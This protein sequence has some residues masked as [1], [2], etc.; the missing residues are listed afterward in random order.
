[1]T[2]PPAL[3]RALRLGFRSILSSG[4]AGALALAQPVA[5]QLVDPDFPSTN[6]T[7]L[8][9]VRV[10]TTLYVGG[11]FTYVGRPTGGAAVVDATSGTPA[12]GLPVVF[13]AVFACASDG[14]GGWYIGGQFTQVGDQPRQNL[15][16]ILADMSVAPWNPGTDGPV[17]A[18]AASGTAVYVGGQFTTLAGVARQDLGAVHASTGAATTWDPQVNDQVFA[19]AVSGDGA[20]V[21]AG[22]YFTEVGGH[23]RLHLAAIRTS[24]GNPTWAPN[25]DQPVTAL[26]LRGTTLYVGGAFGTIDGQSRSAI[27]AINTANGSATAFAPNANSTVYALAVSDDGTIVYAGGGFTSIGGQARS[28]IAA[29]NASDGLATAWD[30]SA[31]FIVHALAAAGSTVYVGG[32]FTSIAGQPVAYGAGLDAASGAMT[33][34]NLVPDSQIRALGVS[35][36]QV[37]AGGYF[38]MVGGTPRRNLAAIDLTTGQVN[39]WDPSANGA[40]LSLGAIGSTIY[41]VG[42]FTSIGGAARSMAGAV[43][44]TTGLATGWQP[45]FQGG[46]DFPSQPWPPAVHDLAVYGSIVYLGGKFAGINGYPRQHLGAV[47]ATNGQPTSWE[48]HPTAGYYSDANVRMLAATSS[49]VGYSQEVLTMAVAMAGTATEMWRSS[50]N[51]SSMLFDGTTLYIGGLF[52]DVGGQPRNHLAA[53][54]YIY[55][56]ILPWNPGADGN[57]SAMALD[58]SMLYLGGTFSNVA[59][60]PR[61]G[62]AVLDVESETALSWNPGTNGTVLALIVDGTTIYAGGEFTTAGTQS[63]R[64]LA[65]IEAQPTVDVPIAPAAG[66]RLVAEPHPM[67]DYTRVRFALPNAGP[68]TLDLYDLAGRL[69]RRILAGA[70]R[71]AGPQ[72]LR[73]ERDGLRGGLYILSL[74]GGGVSTRGKL[75]VLP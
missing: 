64:N 7:V 52:T 2:T 3:A 23:P 6:G 66:A 54:D 33:S 10:G 17:R 55:G 45:T 27:A 39:A 25:P 69:V 32:Q 38:Q 58:G 16:H 44:A 14:Q 19:L 8:D 13:G 62:L 49:A 4:I 46:V 21:Y 51:A 43:D 61:Q 67:R 34:W 15:A 41:A 11:A 24:N 12:P 50:P 36:S 65:A 53:V 28:R 5:A 63:V 71:E 37:L 68:V 72:E 9:L 1:M 48:P 70:S 59:G 57:V 75:V 20:M 74:E 18:L 42:Q 60:Q 40:I 73:I 22:G 30:P 56:Q 35:G 29:L 31:S 47:D 26:T